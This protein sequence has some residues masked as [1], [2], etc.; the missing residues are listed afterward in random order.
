MCGL[1]M[2]D[3]PQWPRRYERNMRTRP[4]TKWAAD[5]SKAKR[6]P[7]LSSV[8]SMRRAARRSKALRQQHDKPHPGIAQV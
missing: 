8:R 5:E 6:N 7:H 4:T 2:P 3:R 1:L